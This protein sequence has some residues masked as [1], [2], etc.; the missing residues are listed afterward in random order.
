MLQNE[1]PYIPKN[2][3][4]TQFKEHG[5]LFKTFF[6]LENAERNHAN[7]PSPYR[8]HKTPRRPDPLIGTDS[9]RSNPGTPLGDGRTLRENGPVLQLSGGMPEA[10]GYGLE[11]LRKEL[12]AARRQSKKK[13]GQYFPKA[14]ATAYRESDI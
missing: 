8:R 1:F 12:A 9:P 3:I 11:S 10:R 13:E 2:Y 5:R 6:V 7:S 4:V 14:N